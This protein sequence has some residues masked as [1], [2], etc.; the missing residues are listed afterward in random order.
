MKLFTNCNVNIISLEIE[1]ESAHDKAD[2]LTRR[3]SELVR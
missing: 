3:T 2:T 1:V